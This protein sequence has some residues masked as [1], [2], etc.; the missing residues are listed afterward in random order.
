[1]LSEVSMLSKKLGPKLSQ[2]SWFI[3]NVLAIMR[4]IAAAMVAAAL[5]IGWF[6]ES[7]PGV[8]VLACDGMPE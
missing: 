8:P 3:I 2:F 5:V 7:A 4:G 1:M 6:E